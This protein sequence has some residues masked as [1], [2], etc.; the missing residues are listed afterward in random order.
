MTVNEDL[1]RSAKRKMIRTA[2]R[3]VGDILDERT[4]ELV[5]TGRIEINEPEVDY[6]RDLV[7]YVQ[8]NEQRRAAT[9]PGEVGE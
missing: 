3:V 2:C 8:E 7:K 1:R 6:I 4:C 5:N 9:V